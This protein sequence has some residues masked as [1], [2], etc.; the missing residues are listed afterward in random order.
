[1][2]GTDPIQSCLYTISDSRYLTWSSKMIQLSVDSPYK[3]VRLIAFWKVGHVCSWI[4][5]FLGDWSSFLPVHDCFLQIRNV[6]ATKKTT[7]T[8]KNSRLIGSKFAVNISSKFGNRLS[9]LSNHIRLYPIRLLVRCWFVFCAYI[10]R[11][12][13]FVSQMLLIWVLAIFLRVY[14]W[15]SASFGRKTQDVFL[16][17]PERL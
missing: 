1:M 4:R 6:I 17:T 5:N 8:R 11:T 16:P 2:V 7:Q 9:K 12:C 3:L 14:D 15:S 13:F 10:S